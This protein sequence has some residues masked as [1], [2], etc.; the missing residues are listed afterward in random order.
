MDRGEHGK[1]VKRGS[2]GKKGETSFRDERC[3]G[4]KRMDIATLRKRYEERRRGDAVEKG[5][6]VLDRN[7]RRGGGGGEVF[8][9]YPVE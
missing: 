2:H 3:K 8:M 6:G 7:R 1:D 9:K 5:G 4:R